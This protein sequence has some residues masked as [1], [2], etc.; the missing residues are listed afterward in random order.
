MNLDQLRP[1]DEFW[2]DGSI[3][4]VGTAGL[5]VRP[6]EPATDRGIVRLG[7]DAADVVLQEDA[8][9]ATHTGTPFSP[10]GSV[11]DAIAVLPNERE[12]LLVTQRDAIGTAGRMM[13]ARITW[14]RWEIAHAAT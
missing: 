13:G 9:A 14:Q 10:P 3:V 4:L 12:R 7:M 1:G 5:G 2:T 11:R 8:P 6:G